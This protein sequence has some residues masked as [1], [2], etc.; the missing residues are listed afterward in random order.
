MILVRFILYFLDTPLEKYEHRLQKSI[1]F[2][3]QG[4]IKN[5]SLKYDSKSQEKIDKLRDELESYKMNNNNKESFTNKNKKFPN[6][7]IYLDDEIN[8]LRIK[9]DELTHENKELTKKLEIYA[10]KSKGFAPSSSFKSLVVS[11]KVVNEM[12]LATKPS[13]L[14]QNQQ[15]N[16][17]SEVSKLANFYYFRNY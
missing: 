13:S 14:S 9:N 4:V 5:F 15:V 10:N 12:F 16:E 2:S 3:K 6:N 8:D 17:T 11:I 1:E 7:N